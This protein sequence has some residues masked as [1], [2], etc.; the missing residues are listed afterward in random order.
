MDSLPGNVRWWM[1]HGGELH[2]TVVRL[3]KPRPISEAISSAGGVAWAELDDT[4]MLHKLPGVWVCGEM[5][6]WEAPTGGYLLQGCLTTGT[7]AANGVLALEVT[8]T[9]V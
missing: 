3:E 5:I 2:R 1:E 7:A 9:P 4:L 6:E 8:S